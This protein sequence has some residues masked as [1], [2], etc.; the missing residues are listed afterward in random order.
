M[1]A[2][3]AP[4]RL[5]SAGRP[6]RGQLGEAGGDRPAGSG[7]RGRAPR[8]PL[9]RGAARWRVGVEPA[10]DHRAAG[11]R[12]AGG[13]RTGRPG[14]AGD[15]VGGH[16]VASSARSISSSMLPRRSQAIALSQASESAGVHGSSV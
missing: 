15:L 6:R 1:P 14:R 13:G 9:A 2:P 16:A 4:S 3:P 5:G 12:S 8:P 10:V 11:R 7:V